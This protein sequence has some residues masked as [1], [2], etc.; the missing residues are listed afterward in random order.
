MLI[1]VASGYLGNALFK[2]FSAS[3]SSADHFINILHTGDKTVTLENWSVVNSTFSGSK[4]IF[5]LTA[6]TGR[7]DIRNI[8]FNDVT[9]DNKVSAI[10][11]SD[12]V[13]VNIYNLTV[14]HVH[15]I[16]DS[17]IS[18]MILDLT[19]LS[20]KYDGAIHIEN[21]KVTDSSIALM[22]IANPSQLKT[23]NQSVSMSKLEYKDSVF[24]S[25]DGIISTLDISSSSKFVLKFT[26]FTFRNITFVRIGYLMYFQHQCPDQLLLTNVVLNNLYQSTIIIG[27][28]NTGIIANKTRVK[29]TN[30]LAHDNYG[31]KFP[32]IY[33]VEGARLEIHN[34]TFYNIANVFTASVLYAGYQEA[35]ADIYNSKF[36]N[37]TS[38]EGGVFATE[39]KSVIR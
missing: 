21:V 22:K 25:R 13:Q 30:M 33:I 18:N 31:N 27:S 24:Q 35:A 8:S 23:V 5:S 7:F 4:S 39:D 16:F 12:A 20:S 11:I 36:Y 34:S 1:R 2:N 15:Q 32:S 9:L 26:D 6:S 19:H 28:Y 29:I 10:Q 3:D 37:N 38:V 17:D 14:T